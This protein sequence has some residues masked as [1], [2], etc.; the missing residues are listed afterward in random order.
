MT[1]VP[2]LTASTKTPSS[3]GVEIGEGGGGDVLESDNHM[4]SGKRGRGLVRWWWEEREG[5]GGSGF[6]LGG[7]TSM[8]K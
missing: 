8:T 1:P 7:E 4:D 3:T 2:E 5:G 6:D